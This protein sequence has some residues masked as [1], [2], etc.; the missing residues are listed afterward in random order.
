VPGAADAG[1]NRHARP[2][3]FAFSQCETRIP[4]RLCAGDERQLREPIEHID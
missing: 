1:A 2:I 3:L 4:N